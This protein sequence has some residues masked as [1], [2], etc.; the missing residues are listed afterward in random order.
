V[1]AV[2]TRRRGILLLLLT[3]LLWGTTFPANKVATAV[4][5]PA[6]LV[7]LRFGVAA[8]LLAPWL[9]RAT[10]ATLRDGLLTG[11]LAV[12]S[13]F[14]FVLGITTISGSR[15]GFLIGMNVV[16]VPLAMP[17]LGRALSGRAIAGALLA[18]SGLAVLAVQVGSLSLSVGDL[19]VLG[20]ATSFAAYVLVMDA[21]VHGHDALALSAVQLSTA[22]VLALAWSLHEGA[23]WPHL[24][25]EGL[26]VV[27]WLGI[28][29]TALPTWAQVVGQRVVAPAQAAVIY[30]L[31]PVFAAACSALWLG[32]RLGLREWLGGALIL[33]GTLACLAPWPA[34]RTTATAAP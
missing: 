31:E 16:L 23:A 17:L 11:V 21:R 3:T 4:L 20:S 24:R 7:S 32:E 25:G 8:L 15:A 34:D 27:A 18:A 13:Y 26:W 6:Q 33:A 2:L 12:V 22:F 1:T 14:T 28:A 5:S 9:R 10:R 30:A 19:W 29:C